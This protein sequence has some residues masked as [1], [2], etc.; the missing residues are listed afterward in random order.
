[1]HFGIYDAFYSQNAHQQ[2]SAGF[3]DFFRVIFLEQEYSCGE[4]CHHNSIIITT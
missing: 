2:V 1:M 3:P 4:L